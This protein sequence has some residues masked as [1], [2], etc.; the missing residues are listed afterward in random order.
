MNSV[1]AASGQ[2]DRKWRWLLHLQEAQ[3]G[4]EYTG[5]CLKRCGQGLITTVAWGTGSDT[6]GGPNLLTGPCV[7]FCHASLPAIILVIVCLSLCLGKACFICPLPQH[8]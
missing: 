5:Q 6:T 3:E 7:Y 4:L 1:F 8:P 2:G